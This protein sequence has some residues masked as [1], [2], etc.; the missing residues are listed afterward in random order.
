MPASALDPTTWPRWAVMWALAVAIFV[1]CKLLTW[2]RTPAPGATP[3]RQ[4]AYLFLWPGLDAAAFLNP[5]PLPHNRRPSLAEALFAVAKVL[6]GA[7]LVWVVVPLVQEE[8]PLVRGWVG[9]SGLIF[10]LHFGTFHL[11]SCAWRAAGV[12]AKPLMNWPVRATSLSEFWGKRW[13]TAF[14]DLT[15][16]FLFAPLAKKLGPRTGLA[17][18]FLFSGIVHDAVISAPAGG[19]YG[20]P[21]LYFVAQGFG[22]LAERSKF[23]RRLGLGKGAVGWAFTALVVAGPALALFHTPF[24]MNIIVPFLAVL[25]AL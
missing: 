25:G 23:G 11:L 8:R 10:L 3:R 20:L 7:G 9:M 2:L 19:G 21:T 16:R 5:A 13:N 17:A 6:L 24:V 1:A 22:L 15:H 18:G 12:D 14:R 4:L